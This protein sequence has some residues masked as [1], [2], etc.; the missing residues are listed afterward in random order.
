MA[1]GGGLFLIL[2]VV[3][4]GGAVR[5]AGGP[6]AQIRYVDVVTGSDDGNECSDAG[7]PC[8]S[9]Q[10]A[11]EEA[12]AGDEIRVAAGVY[13]ADVNPVVRVEKTLTI[14]GGY[15]TADWDE[16]DVEANV[17][18]LDGEGNRR[19]IR[20]ADEVAPTGDV[21]VTVEGLHIVDGHAS[22]G[23]GVYVSD[24][25]LTLRN[26]WLSDNFAQG[27]GGALYAR[28]SVLTLTVNHIEGNVATESGFDPAHG[29]GVYVEDGEDVVLVG[30]V[31]RDNQVA[32]QGGG[33]GGLYLDGSEAVLRG[34][35]FEGNQGLAFCVGGAL[36]AEDSTLQ[37]MGNRVLSNTA[38]GGGGLYVEGGAGEGVRN[39]FAF[40]AADPTA[41]GAFG[42]EM[43]ARAA[44]FGATGV[45]G[46]VYVEDAAFVFSRNEFA[47]NTAAIDGGGIYVEGGEFH[48]ESSTVVDNMAER[49]G[50]GLYVSAAHPRL[51]HTTLA[52][53]VGGDGCGLFVT[54]GGTT[55]LTNTI[56]VSHTVGLMVAE[57]STVTLSSTLWGTD[58]WANGSD[59][60]GG[61]AVFTGSVASNYR[62]APAFVAP[63]EGD[64]HITEAS[65]A[66]DR[67]VDTAVA[68]DVDGHPRRIGEAS[69]LG[70]DE[71]GLFVQLPLVLRGH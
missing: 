62:V 39:L 10:H 68:E 26:S 37:L 17:T 1:I 64:Y 55:A 32:A 30:N 40:N 9:I 8:Q 52:R 60:S 45:G 69:D 61:G 44:A 57:G 66:L 59:W 2:L 49:N 16:A 71:W 19:L 11:V 29:G 20:I 42:E 27:D 41:G 46:A 54:A 38:M 12:N 36:L 15:S 7:A 18:T 63:D 53:N 58:T 14:R 70:A 23:G 56:L 24:A 22:Q 50:A 65:G 67:G 31:V 4:S 25:A 47:G 51:L 3:L 6:A 13:T 5:G 43:G 34:N 35:V 21:T 48:L 28:R 33:G